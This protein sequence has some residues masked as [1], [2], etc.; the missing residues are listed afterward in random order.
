MKS[1][2]FETSELNK[3]QEVSVKH[4]L[5]TSKN[6]YF[7]EF[8]SLNVQRRVNDIFVFIRIDCPKFDRQKIIST[9]K[10]PTVASGHRK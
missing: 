9:S 6:V 10:Y 7:L 2:C 1:I 8:F 3:Q 4:L 5:S